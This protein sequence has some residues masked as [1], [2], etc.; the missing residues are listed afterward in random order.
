MPAVNRTATLQQSRFSPSDISVACQYDAAKFQLQFRVDGLSFE[1][2]SAV[3]ETGSILL[4]FE[5]L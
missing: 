4:A 5:S 3:T 1:V 2:P